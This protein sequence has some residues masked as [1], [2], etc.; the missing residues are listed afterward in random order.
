MYLDNFFISVMRLGMV[1]DALMCA[2][3][4]ALPLSTGVGVIVV[5]MYPDNFFISVMSLGMVG[6]ALMCADVPW[7]CG[8]GGHTCVEVSRGVSSGSSL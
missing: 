3:A 6:Y 7:W 8:G 1:G 2:D 5:N 4:A